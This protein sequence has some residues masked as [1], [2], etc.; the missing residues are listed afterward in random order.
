MRTNP[1]MTRTALLTLLTAGAL[2]LGG[3][4]VATAADGQ[5]QPAETG[6]A[7]GTTMM[8]EG[9][10]Q[11]A[12]MGTAR[13]TTT[14]E[15]GQGSGMQ[16]DGQTEGGFGEGEQPKPGTPETGAEDEQDGAW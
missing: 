10:G 16:T 6:T 5:G 12:G 8:E 1:P 9:Q 2:S 13:G 3:I 14:M 15:E 4:G 7:G 11:S